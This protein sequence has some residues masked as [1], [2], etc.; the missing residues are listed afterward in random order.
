LEKKEFMQQADYNRIEA[1][2]HYN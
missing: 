1:C 2:I